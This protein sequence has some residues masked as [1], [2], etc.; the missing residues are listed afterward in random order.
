MLLSSRASVTGR[1]SIMGGGGEL[2]A[3]KKSAVRDRGWWFS[4]TTRRLGEA[5]GGRV[6]GRVGDGDRVPKGELKKAC[7]L[8]PELGGGVVEGDGSAGR[9]MSEKVE[10][11]EDALSEGAKTDMLWLLLRCG[12]AC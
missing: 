6:G 8:E 7:V 10:R 3:A 1:T 5:A 11:E 4:L 2:A 12:C 9:D